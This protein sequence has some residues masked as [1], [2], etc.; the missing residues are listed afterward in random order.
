MVVEKQSIIEPL[1]QNFF[2]PLCFL[3]YDD[4]FTPPSDFSNRKVR[5]YAYVDISVYTLA[6]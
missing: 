2:N 1:E 3:E 5:T 4:P 6:S